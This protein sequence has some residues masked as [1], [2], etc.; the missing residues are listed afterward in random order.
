MSAVFL[1]IINC[2]VVGVFCL[3]RTRKRPFNILD[4]A[5]AFLAGY[6]INYCFRPALFL[7]F[8][9]VALWYEDSLQPPSAFRAALSG[10]LSFALCGLLGFVLGDFCC[11]RLAKRISRRLP[12]TT[13][14]SLARTRSYTVL[15]TL[16]LVSGV[17]G[18]W[19][20]IHQSGWSGSLLVLLTGTQRN[21][22]ITLDV[23][24]GHGYYTFMMQLS[25]FGWALLCAQWFTDPQIRHGW[26]RGIH[27]LWCVSCGVMTL[28]VWVAMG[29][30]STIVAVI[31]IPFALY[32]SLRVVRPG[33]PRKS[34]ILRWGPVILVVVVVVAGPLGLLMKQQEVVGPQIANMATSA[35]DAMEFTVRTP[36]DFHA[37][38]LFWG[39]SYL[40][41]IFYTWYPR[42]IFSSK[43]ERYGIMTVQ[44]HL[45]PAL[46]SADGT[47]PPGV[48]VEAFANFSYIG[49]FFIPF[50]CAVLYRAVYLKLQN[51]SFYWHIQMAILYSPMASFRSLGSVMAFFEANVFVLG[52]AIVIC[53]IVPFF[54]VSRSARSSWQKHQHAM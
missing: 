40:G 28:L 39:K 37:R 27:V 45:A 43:P 46:A 33:A 25:I 1:L 8:P 3:V 14:G 47:F 41:D 32:S 53:R 15:A 17:A 12:E 5:W 21:T 35:W 9:D 50:A 51:R 22:F 49:L 26:R 34:S 16:F 36:Q 24:Q 4:P 29:E 30:R 20:F 48:L 7:T 19:G 13:L 2:I 54:V 23:L 10:A 11:P 52:L 42:A 44:D 18:L 38:D 31:F 6:F